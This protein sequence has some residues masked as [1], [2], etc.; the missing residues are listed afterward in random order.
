[1]KPL[2]IVNCLVAY[3]PILGLE[4]FQLGYEQ[5]LQVLDLLV[6]KTSLSPDV[7]LQLSSVLDKQHRWP[8]T[9]PRI[10]NLKI[11]VR[12]G[13]RQVGDDER[14]AR[15]ACLHPLDDVAGEG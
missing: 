5:F 10:A 1:M 6:N 15:D 12:I 8:T 7:K 13:P 4:A 9:T 2:H 14:R 3:C 11:D